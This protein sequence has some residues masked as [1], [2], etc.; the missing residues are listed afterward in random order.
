[1]SLSVDHFFLSCRLTKYS[2][3]H[4]VQK[5]RW[6]SLISRYFSSFERGI[7]SKDGSGI[8][9]DSSRVRKWLD[10]SASISVG[11]LLSAHKDL[12]FNV[13]TIC[14]NSVFNSSLVNLWEPID[15]N[16]NTFI[17]FMLASHSPPKCGDEGGLKCQL[18]C[19]EDRYCWFQDWYVS[20]CVN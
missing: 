18:I 4:R 13:A 7:A 10:V 14:V 9:I 2:F 20:E 16:I 12:E 19:L 3:V 11:S 6:R 5:C 17:D 15:R 8:D 1:M